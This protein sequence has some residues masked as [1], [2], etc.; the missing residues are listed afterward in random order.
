MK[1]VLLV[2]EALNLGMAE[3]LFEERR[4]LETHR[5]WKKG[6]KEL[7]IEGFE[8]V[9]RTEIA[10]EKLKYYCFGVLKPVV[11]GDLRTVRI[12]EDE[13]E[14]LVAFSR[15]KTISLHW[16]GLFGSKLEKMDQ[17]SQGAFFVRLGTARKQQLDFGH[18]AASPL[19]RFIL[20]WWDSEHKD[21]NGQLIP[22]LCCCS[23]P[24]IAEFVRLMSIRRCELTAESVSKTWKRLGLIKS[25]KIQYWSVK[26]VQGKIVF[27]ESRH[28][29]KRTR[30]RQ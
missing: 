3:C 12:V 1:S 22:P 29:K 9:L 20:E 2:E 18:V 27:D 17:S 11:E 14:Q 24:A 8:I 19:R 16:N 6:D 30:P 7:A 10:R 5:W 15:F 28:L 23:D 26:K 4:G 25:A 21:K 13:H